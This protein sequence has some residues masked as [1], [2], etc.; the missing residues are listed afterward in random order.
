MLRWLGIKSVEIKREPPRPTIG[1]ELDLGT[2]DRTAA[3][4][5]RSRPRSGKPDTVYAT[6]L[7]GGTE[8]LSLVYAGPPKVLVQSFQARATP[9][10]E[11]SVGSADAVERLKID[12][13]LAYWITGAHG[14][15]FQAKDS[16]GY[17]Q[18]R[19]SD[20]VLLLERD[21][22]LL[23]VEGAISRDRAVEI[24]K[25]AIGTGGL[26]PSDPPLSSSV[27]SGGIVAS[28]A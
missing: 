17:E 18:Q 21:G 10:I 14:F 4:R 11:K 23:R 8:A 24:A 6:T 27:G 26:P 15:A 12:G 19:L 28:S 13:H 22:V 25:S 7:P 16:V 1:R 2:A 20:R 9:F 3:R 5:A